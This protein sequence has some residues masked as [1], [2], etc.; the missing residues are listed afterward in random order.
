MIDM[1]IALRALRQLA[2]ASTQCELD[3]ARME[4]MDVLDQAGWEKSSRAVRH[5][6]GI[7]V[8][9]PQSPS[10]GRIGPGVP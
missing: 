2:L 1:T 4:A 3:A 6:I 5:A 9:R 10:P 7:P 8:A